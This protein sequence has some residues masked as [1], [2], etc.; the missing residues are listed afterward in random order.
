VGWVNIM[1]MFDSS[2]G[3]MDFL[4]E[5]CMALSWRVDARK[6]PT[7]ALQRYCRE[8]EEKI[9]AA[10]EL[11]YLPK[12]RRREIRDMV[13]LRLLKRAIPAS[14]TYDVIW[15]LKTGVLIFGATS[16]K[17]ADEFTEFFLK[18]FNLRLNSIFPYTLA[19]R[20]FEKEGLDTSLLDDAT[21]TVFVSE[22][23]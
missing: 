23:R 10:E 8:A 17:L 20:V 19:M 4:K 21:P 15:N 2:F 1:D 22:G 9:K 3:N 13:R 18:C 14:Q 12:P 6:V 11:E 16:P 5:P 7:K